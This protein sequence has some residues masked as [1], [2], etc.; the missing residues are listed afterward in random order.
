MNIH[1]TKHAHDKLSILERHQCVISL[2][3]VTEAVTQ[4]DA[5]D[6]THRSFVIAEKTIAPTHV[7]RVVYKVEDDIRIVITFYPSKP[8]PHVEA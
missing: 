4:P 7:L 3:Q 5:L 2:E 8:K 6:T 1:V